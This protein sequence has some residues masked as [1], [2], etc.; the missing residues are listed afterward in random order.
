[1]YKWRCRYYCIVTGGGVF[2]DINKILGWEEVMSS[3]TARPILPGS[4]SEFR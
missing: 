2:G 3:M 1:M 4:I